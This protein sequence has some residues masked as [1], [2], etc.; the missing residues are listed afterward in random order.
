MNMYAI[1][2]FLWH[3]LLDADNGSTLMLKRLEAVERV[4]EKEEKE[5]TNVMP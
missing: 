3:R 4:R 5:E 2:C 1:E